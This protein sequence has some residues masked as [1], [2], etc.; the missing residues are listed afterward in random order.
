MEG[1]PVLQGR[2]RV[3][4]LPP[5]RPAGILLSRFYRSAYS[6]SA[7]S[8]RARDPLEVAEP[9]RYDGPKHGAARAQRPLAPNAA[10]GHTC[11]VA[12]GDEHNP[13]TTTRCS[14]CS[15]TH[16]IEEAAHSI[17]ETAGDIARALNLDD[18]ADTLFQP[19]TDE[20]R[21]LITRIVDPEET[22][23]RGRPRADTRTVAKSCE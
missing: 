23:G 3:R 14:E 22:R 10:C 20:Q 17:P 1:E 12:T 9:C 5:S 15:V 6:G 8:G 21:M 19:L 16:G 11:V 2:P 7:V 13:V 18:G 4:G